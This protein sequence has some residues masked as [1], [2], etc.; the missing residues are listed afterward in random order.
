MTMTA[1]PR[2]TDD[3]KNM[4]EQLLPRGWSCTSIR[5]GSCSSCIQLVCGLVP[6][7]YHQ[8]PKE[9]REIVDLIMMNNKTLSPSTK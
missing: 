6:M 4:L 3:I 2:H 5:S 1:H 9:I 7:P 8:W